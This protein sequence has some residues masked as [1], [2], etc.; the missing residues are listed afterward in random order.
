MQRRMGEQSETMPLCEAFLRSASFPTGSG[1][2]TALFDCAFSLRLLRPVSLETG[3]RPFGLEKSPTFAEK[4][5]ETGDNPRNS[6]SAVGLS[7]VGVEGA[8]CA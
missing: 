3:L 5:A 8:R 4:N 2:T 1:F 7:K 6:N